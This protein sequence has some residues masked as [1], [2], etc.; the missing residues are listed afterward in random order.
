[1][2]YFEKS[3]SFA[4]AFEVRR[5]RPSATQGSATVYLNGQEI[6]TFSDDIRMI[7][8]GEKY[9]GPLIGD[10]ASVTPDY[11]FIRALLWNNL[12]SIYHYS[13]RPKAI[14]EQL[15]QASNPGSVR[16]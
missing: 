8:P 11:H 16:T 6:I 3:V 9:Y 4:L 5:D 2:T 13:D 15:C 1:M 12:D 10:W 7:R 14:I